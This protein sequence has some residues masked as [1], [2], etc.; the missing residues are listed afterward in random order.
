MVIL[1]LERKDVCLLKIFN[2]AFVGIIEGRLKTSECDQILSS[3]KV[4]TFFR[5]CYACG[6]VLQRLSEVIHYNDTN[7]YCPKCKAGSL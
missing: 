5:I 4:K 7:W 1:I 3:I 2:M 6:T